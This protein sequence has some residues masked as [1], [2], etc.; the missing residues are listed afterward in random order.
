MLARRSV[1][2]LLLYRLGIVIGLLSVW[3]AA[4][5]VPLG[6]PSLLP[7]PSVVGAQAWTMATDGTL[8]TNTAQSIG[9][10]ISGWGIAIVLGVPT[11]IAMGSWRAAE[12]T[13]GT[14]VHLLRPISPVAWIP[15]AILLFGFGVGGPMFIVFLA[16]FYPIVLASAAAVRE[17]ETVQISAVRT[18]GAGEAA[19]F[20][21]VILP[22]SLPGVLLGVRIALGN[23][24]A[25]V[26]AAELF[27]AQGGLGYLISKSVA[28]V[29]LRNV[30]VGIVLIGLTGFVLDAI[31]V[32]VMDRWLSWMPR[33]EVD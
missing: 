25:A 3:E 17:V 32:V 4:Q 5:A 15:F 13:V 12:D 24:W 21:E 33:R 19:I 28:F 27:G 22:G 2:W 29:D 9:R 11:G 10:I 6:N 31:Y 18:L 30:M 1:P 23:A 20:R 8:F 26:V 16:A 14:I 7:R